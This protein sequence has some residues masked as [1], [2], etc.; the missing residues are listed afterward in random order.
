MLT[1]QALFTK[2]GLYSFALLLLTLVQQFFLDE[3]SLMG[4]VPFLTPMVV[5][6]VASLEGS[7]PGTIF[8]TFVGFLC[9]L[10]G[11]GVFPGVYTLSFFFVAL[12]VAMIAKSWVRHSAPGSLIYGALSFLISDSIQLLYLVLL[13]G[14]APAVFLRIAGCELLLSIVFVIPIFYLYSFLHRLFRYE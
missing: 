13:R 10:S 14:A 11:S 3:L 8:G 7:I 6:V 1:S 4:V 5:A 9:D 12:G 2:W